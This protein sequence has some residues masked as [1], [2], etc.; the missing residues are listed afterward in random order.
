[1]INVVAQVTVL[2]A[3]GNVVCLLCEG[4]TSVKFH[5]PGESHFDLL[6]ISL[7]RLMRCGQIHCQSLYQGLFH[8]VDLEEGYWDEDWRC[9]CSSGGIGEI[10][11]ERFK[12]K[13]LPCSSLVHCCISL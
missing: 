9:R 10:F 2:V 11:K 5:S 4:G 3:C 13:T 6:F 7:P 1:M 8:C 12:A